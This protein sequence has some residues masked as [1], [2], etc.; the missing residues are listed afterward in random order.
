MQVY[1]LIDYGA[2]YIFVFYKIMN[3]LLVLSSN[4]GVGLM[5]IIIFFLNFLKDLN[6]RRG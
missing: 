6:G 5:V 4:L 3:N 1:T 2:S